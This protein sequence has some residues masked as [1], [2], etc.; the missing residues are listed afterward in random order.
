MD[1]KA[2]MYFSVSPGYWRVNVPAGPHVISG[3]RQHGYHGANDDISQVSQQIKTTDYRP[4]G[5]VDSGLK[6]LPL[7]ENSA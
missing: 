3:A 5:D 4:V 1:G 6:L 7:V 2:T